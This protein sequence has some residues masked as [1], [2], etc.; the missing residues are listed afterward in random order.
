[1]DDHKEKTEIKVDTEKIKE[2]LTKNATQVIETVKKA[3]N[4]AGGAKGISE[5]VA[6]VAGVVAGT[7]HSFADKAVQ[8]DAVKTTSKKIQET[9]VAKKFAQA[10][11]KA[12]EKSNDKSCKCSE[13]CQCDKKCEDNCQCDTQNS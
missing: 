7:I 4:D 2:D 11:N 5:K 1:M 10:H 3:Y 9:D 12:Y 8:S 6:E 13:S